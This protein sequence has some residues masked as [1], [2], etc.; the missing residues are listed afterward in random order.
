MVHAKPTLP[1]GHGE[2]LCR[3]AFEEWA[4]LVAKNRT[5]AATWAFDVAGVDVTEL[6]SLARREAL[7]RA[8]EFST[9]LGVPV[10]A[11]GPPDAPIV[12]TGHQPELYHPGVWIKDFLLQRLADETGATAL[13]IVVDTDGFETV[14]VHSPCLTPGVSRCQQYLA[15]GGGDACYAGA[16]VPSAADLSDFCSAAGE[17]LSSL[18]APAISRHFSAFCD[19]LRGAAETAEN[20]GELTT[21]ARRRYEA[22]AGTDY[23]EL[24]LTALGRTRAWVTFVADIALSAERF[25][26]A[27]NAELAE[28][29]MANKTRSAAQPFPDL[30]REGAFIE[31]PLWRIVDGHRRNVRV[32]PLR[33]GGARIVDEDGEQVV[34][35]SA[36]GRAAVANLLE[37]EQHFAPK[38]LALTLFA[39]LFVGDLMIHG[40]GGGRYDRVTDGV[41]RR[42][43]G[44][45]AP[46][47]VVA[48]MTMYLP[49]GAH[50]VTDQEVAAAR[51]R[52]NRLDHNPD[53]L[54][55]EVEFDSAAEQGRAASLAAEKASLVV[56]IAVPGADKKTLGQRIREVNTELS[57]LLAPLKDGLAAE[58]ASLESQFEASEILTDR[59]YP[60]CFW[61][62][63]EVADKA[64]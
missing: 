4:P 3:P 51:E 58:L 36:D 53:V 33:D 32:E 18:S 47:F 24:P 27:Y 9:K 20:L 28:Y 62:P 35:L 50:L 14:A 13:D 49:L 61:S 60:F 12:M 52:L 25:S 56:A 59:T 26:S 43:F 22:C 34:E 29:R 19:Q 5:L 6:R 40:V 48:S 31:L 46:A 64:R 55:G 11:P 42:Y 45:E 21:I 2:V 30:A 57:S 10:M 41:C 15:V 38:A 44:V 1:V 63:E 16:G 7:E 37:S 54:L 39:R 8:A 17:M 23:L